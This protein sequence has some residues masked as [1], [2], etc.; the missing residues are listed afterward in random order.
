MMKMILERMSVNNVGI[1]VDLCFLCNLYFMIMYLFD[2]CLLGK[3]IKQ[4]GLLTS[5]LL[6]VGIQLSL[7]AFW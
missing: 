5:F 6:L 4:Y 1:Q 3:L 7:S 2:F